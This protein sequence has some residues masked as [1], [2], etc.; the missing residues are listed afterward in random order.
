MELAVK[1]HCHTQTQHEYEVVAK[2]VDVVLH[3]S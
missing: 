2:A 1:Q 3:P